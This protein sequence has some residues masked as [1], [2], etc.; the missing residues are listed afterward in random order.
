MLEVVKRYLSAIILCAGWA[1]A[2]PASDPIPFNPVPPPMV[3][4]RLRAYAR[5]NKE[6]EPALR[7][8]FED[9]GCGGDAL[10]EQ[11]VKGQKAPNLICTLTGATDSTIIVGAHFD[12]IDAGRGVVDNWSG[13]ALLSSLYQSLAGS[14][15]RHTFEFVAF[16]GEEAGLIGSRAFVKQ[17]RPRR[18]RIKAMVNMDSLGLS[19]TNVWESHADPE[20]VRWLYAVAKSDKLPLSTVNVDQVGTRDS[21]PFREA[22][23]PAIT[24]HSVNQITFDVLHSPRDRIEAIKLDAYYRSYQLMLDYLGVLDQKLD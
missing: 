13:A 21:E 11:P 7:P 9:A 2:Q 8:L 16:T 23:I 3:E 24:V 17:I 4:A 15:R 19:E 10:T 14:P 6:R 5:T 20:L 1:G 22:K 18:E 12:F